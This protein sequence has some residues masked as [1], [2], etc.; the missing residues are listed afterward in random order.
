MRE[1][2]EHLLAKMTAPGTFASTLR[3]PFAGISLS[4]SGV[5]RVPLPVAAQDGADIVRSARK[6]PFGLGSETRLDE[7]VRDTWEIPGDHLRVV[8]RSWPSLLEGVVKE[9]RESLGLSSRRRIRV[10]L[11]K[12]LV[13][14]PGQFFVPHQDTERLEG[15][16]G[17][18]LV[19]LP[20]RFAGGRLVIR[21]HGESL[22]VPSDDKSAQELTFVAFY[23]DCRHEVK[24]L[25]SGYRLV[26][27]YHL[28]FDDDAAR[29]GRPAPVDLREALEAYF[30]TPSRPAW[31]EGHP[32]DR[33]VYLLDHEYTERGLGWVR[34]KNGDAVRVEA[35]R[36]AAEADDYGIALA[37]ADVRE[38]WQCE[39]EYSGRGRN[40][41]NGEP[42]PD[43]LVSAEISLERVVGP[44]GL[45]V[46]GHGGYI[47][48]D[49]VVSTIPSSRFDPRSSQ[50]EGYMGNYGHTLDLAYR[51]AAVVLWP[52]RQEFLIRARASPLWGLGEIAADAERGTHAQARQRLESLL[53]HLPRHS[54]SPELFVKAVEVARLV[55]DRGTADE[56][57]SR[58]RLDAITP[59][60][61]PGLAQLGEHFGALVTE[62]WI[63]QWGAR[64][65][66]AAEP[67]VSGLP[68]VTR[69]L[70]DT[71]VEVALGLASKLV[72]VQLRNVADGLAPQL[73]RPITRRLLDYLRASVPTLAE[74]L[75]CRMF[76]APSVEAELSKYL[77]SAPLP[78]VLLF[79][80]VQHAL[81]RAPADEV[82]LWG[83]RPVY[84]RA[85]RE[86]QRVAESPQR[87][88][89]DWHID[90]EL[91]CS[92][93][94]CKTLSSFLK[95]P[96][97]RGLRWPLAK[98][99]RRHIHG[100]I[101]GL[102]LPV[103]HETRRE[104]RP[105]A[106]E[107]IKTPQVFRREEEARARAREAL[108][109]LQAWAHVFSVSRSEK[110][111]SR[112]RRRKARSRPR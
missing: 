38:I 34:L 11:D 79:E 22:E 68:D 107:L 60:T 104:G 80:L 28:V 91:R 61:A 88:E 99:G 14:E 59:V 105:H 23:A 93:E 50:Y 90:I 35:L 66:G 43:Y 100:V 48:S 103:T 2:I 78:P 54:S 37:L 84:G 64:R 41:R 39:E 9:F 56:L 33:L 86:L 63:E 75:E 7:T 3:R 8:G 102:E 108:D 62:G 12:L 5:G 36:R 52:R 10:V 40:S 1:T 18:M 106:L 24:P 51:R 85:V 16:F 98:D 53:P 49:Q 109:T 46:E 20:S 87:D 29:E 92:C 76:A 31:G 69:A 44:D 71:G 30:S 57:L 42:V 112:Q 77:E 96:N 95:A 65:A 55:G 32:P 101:E 73:A 67:L 110:V 21:H 13:Y 27:S 82:E 70:V 26:L 74:L 15:M 47:P 19:I 94:L 72:E 111:G 83:L 25:K 58:F 6:A 89:D 97:Q 17:T 81:A 45:P 4:I